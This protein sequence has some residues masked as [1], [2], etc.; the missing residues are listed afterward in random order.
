MTQ[1]ALTTD[2]PP[3]AGVR[4]RFVDLPGLRM[5]VAEA[6][7][8]EP[9]L[10]LHGF[11]QHWWEWRQVIPGLAERY[12]VIAP[13]LRGSGWTD[14]PPAGYTR[15]QLRDDVVALLDALELESVRVVSHDMG[16]LVAFALSL[17][18]PE[19][20][21]QHVSLGG[22]PP[23]VSFSPRLLPAFR[24][25][26]FQQALATP[27][28][29]SR[30]LS[31]GGQRLPRYLFTH[32]TPDPDVWSADDLDVFV[33]RLRDPRRASAGSALYRKLVL[34]EFPRMM[35]G[36]YN[37]QRLVTPTLLLF[38]A[39]DAAFPPDLVRTLLRGS[40]DHVDDMELSFVEGAAHFIADEKPDEVVARTLA[41]FGP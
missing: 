7:S 25:L 28:L 26:W 14:A 12:Q 16:A 3:L 30:L 9:V 38:G 36:V 5:H 39:A 8:G 34:A 13:D 2:I 31:Q 22:A 35:R 6:G 33:S 24:H 11:P 17:D 20:V 41:F 18:H 15:D 29:G 32:F 40:V 4:H 23:F 19:R 10:L 21:R 27:G 37:D 1:A